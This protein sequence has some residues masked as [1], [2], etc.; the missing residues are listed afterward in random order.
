MKPL[1]LV[2][3][4]LALLLASIAAYAASTPNYVG[5]KP[6]GRAMRRKSRPGRI[7]ITAGP[8]DCRRR[9]TCSAT[10]RMQNSSSR[11]S[12]SRFFSKDGK[13]FVETD[14]ADGKLQTFEIKYV[15][16]IE[17]LQQYL[18]D[19]DHG[20]LQALD[21]AWDT[22]GE[23][24]VSS[25]SE[26]G[27]ERRQRPALDRALQELAGALRRL[28][29]DRLQ[30]ELQREGTAATN[31]LEGP[32]GCLRGVPR[33]G[34]GACRLGEGRRQVRCLGLS[35]YRCAGLL[36]AEGRDEAGNRGEYVRAV[37]FPARASRCQQHIAAIA[38]RRSFQSLD[39]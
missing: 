25:L 7:H 20:R 22:V 23:A 26:R 6:A 35:R 12:R 17:P 14:G 36:K 39:A 29:P 8:C 11:E 1:T 19:T 28:P 38:D 21:L 34:R 15:V 31:D 3:A 10:S 9:K 27:C 37:P 33:A 24:L 2:M 30:Q 4:L 5:P 18:V 13:Y 32:D 16:G